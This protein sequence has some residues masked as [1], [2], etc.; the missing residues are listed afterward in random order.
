MKTVNLYSSAPNSQLNGFLAALGWNLGRE[1]VLLPLAAMPAPD[2]L[3]LQRLRVE[4]T[5]L[6]ESIQHTE[7]S[8][9]MYA[10]GQWQPDA[11][12]E[13]GLRFDLEALKNRLKGVNAV[14]GSV[15]KGGEDNG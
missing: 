6:L 3:R 9:D 7:W 15:E 12:R 8:L 5:E 4:R 11:G 2:P 13:N 1:V 10:S 14:L